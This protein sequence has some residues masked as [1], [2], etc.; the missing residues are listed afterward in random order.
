MPDTSKEPEPASV[1]RMPNA[2]KVAAILLGLLAAMLLINAILT[3][4]GRAAILDRIAVDAQS[5][6]VDY[7]RAALSTELSFSIG[8]DVFVGLIAVSSVVLL[9]RRSTAG[10][11]LG[12]TC[13]VILLILAVLTVVAVGGLPIYSTL[14]IV[15]TGA[16]VFL[17]FRKPTVDWLRPASNT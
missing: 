12:I 4:T 2:T 11:W 14:L 1:T 5:R 10:R 13:A 16:I 15:V 8:R 9:V 17:L 3:A 6:N 7:D